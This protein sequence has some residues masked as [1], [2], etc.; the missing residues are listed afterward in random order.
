MTSNLTNRL[1]LNW[2]NFYHTKW[3]KRVGDYAACKN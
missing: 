3:I 1:L 2:V